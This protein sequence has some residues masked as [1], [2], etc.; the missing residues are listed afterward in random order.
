VLE[1][2]IVRMGKI[3]KELEA[4]QKEKSSADSGVRS[5]AEVK[6]NKL[7]EELETLS[8]LFPDL[9]EAFRNPSKR[10][11]NTDASKKGQHFI[12]INDADD[13]AVVKGHSDAWKARFSEGWMYGWQRAFREATQQL[14]Q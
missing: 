4:V 14:T 3:Y 13:E 6:E 7:R 11:I 1:R 2:A 12:P 8:K 9:E 5:G 10:R